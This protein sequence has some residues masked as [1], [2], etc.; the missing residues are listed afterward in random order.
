MKFKR[1]A[2]MILVG[3]PGVGKGTQAARLISAFPLLSSLSS[4]DLLRSNVQ[5]RTS[6]G[7]AAESTM[8]SGNLV[9]D[10][11][12]LSLILDELRGRGW[13]SQEPSPSPSPSPSTSS[14]PPHPSHAF[15]T[16]PLAA[17]SIPF[18]LSSSAMRTT[19]SSDPSASFILDGFPRTSAQAALLAPHLPINL[20]IHIRTPSAIILERICGR[21]VHPA[22]G[23]VYNTTFNPPRVT[24]KD[25]LTGEPLERRADDEEAIWRERLERFE[26]G[27]KDLLD[28]YADQGVLWEVHGRGSDEITPKILTEI[29]ARFC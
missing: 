16:T 17:S 20:C 5:R 18:S 19:P 8:S 26:E 15:V 9:P 1:A 11:M 23:R 7:L 10:S 12:I 13:L 22:S 2:R 6:L 28:F 3:P 27:S 25:D 14:P 24:G 21:L 29:A 4:G